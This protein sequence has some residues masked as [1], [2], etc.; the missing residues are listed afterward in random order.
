MEQY[1]NYNNKNMNNNSNMNANKRD[2]PMLALCSI[3]CGSSS[4]NPNEPIRI[5]NDIIEWYKLNQNNQSSTLPKP[6]DFTLGTFNFVF[7]CLLYIYIYEC[8]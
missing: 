6:Y 8:D 5:P 1:N 3:R 2:Y 7:T 4:E